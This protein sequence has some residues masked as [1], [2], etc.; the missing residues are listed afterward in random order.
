MGKYRAVTDDLFSVFASQAWR[1]EGVKV[2]PSAFDGEKGDPPYVRYTV[3][4]SGDP[5]NSASTSGVLLAEIYTAWGEGPGPSSDIAD[6]L[7][8]H[9]QHRAVGGTQLFSSSMDRQTRDKYNQSLARSIYS[10][11]YSRFGVA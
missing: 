7:D 6:T 3:V 10:L 11:P 9:L 2:F 1:D 5:L 8:R 4:P